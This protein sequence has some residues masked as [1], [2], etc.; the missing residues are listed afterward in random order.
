MARIKTY[1]GIQPDQPDSGEKGAKR[2]KDKKAKGG[3]TLTGVLATLLGFLVLFGALACLY[4]F[5][6]F[7]TRGF[8]I[9]ALHAKEEAAE[10]DA[11]KLAQWQTDLNNRDEELAQLEKKLSQ[12][13]Q[14]AA[15]REAAVS[16]KE[17]DLVTRE[18]ALE[19]SDAQLHP[20]NIDITSVARAIEK[21][22]I[23]PAGALLMAM[24]D[25]DA[26]LRLFSLLKP[27][28]QAAILEILE[29]ET[30]AALV[31]ALS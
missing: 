16:E 19:E 24:S 2:R 14:G 8:I 5:D 1:K 20:N 18:A 9:D 26:M 30:A 15:Q 10:R 6:L 17:S 23:E 11:A 4:A 27:A 12:R 7:G 25:Q 13:E 3:S 29:A 21:M 28:T 22:K 31:Q